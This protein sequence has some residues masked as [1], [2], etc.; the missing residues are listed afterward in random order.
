M[1]KL[2]FKKINKENNGPASRRRANASQ[3]GYT[4]LET[5]V[6][7]SLFLVVVMTGMGTL[8]NANLLHQKSQ[9]MHSIMDNLNFVIEDISR[10]IRTGYNYRC[11]SSG[12]SI[13]VG[14]NDPTMGEPRSCLSGWAVAFEYAYGDNL[15]TAQDGD[16]IDYND[17][18]V[19]YISN[20]KIF[21][22]T[23]GPYVASS[24]IQLTPDEVVIDAASSF[25]VLGAEPL[26]SNQ[27]QPLIII[28]LVGR[29]TSQNVVTPFSL[30]TSVS[31]RLIDI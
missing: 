9:N 27:Q 21:K 11:F 3:G 18:W 6:A 31:Q 12:Q 16:P 24:F 14:S 5:M 22:S 20:G 19:Y 23:Q 13:P 7:T 1:K 26:S 8:L 2:F 10:N 25:S 4:I 28:K 30:Q 15:D 17:Q 29:I